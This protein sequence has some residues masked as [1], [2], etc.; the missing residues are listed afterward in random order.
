MVLLVLGSLLCAGF[1]AG[2]PHAASHKV[3]ASTRSVTQ[4]SD[5]RR[6][7][8]ANK[9]GNVLTVPLPL[10]MIRCVP[11]VGV[12]LRPAQCAATQGRGTRRRS[13]D[14]KRTAAAHYC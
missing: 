4:Q 14:A 8:I 13:H 12:P 5:S 2:T 7:I 6:R 11:D 1:M 9:T 3:R 10:T